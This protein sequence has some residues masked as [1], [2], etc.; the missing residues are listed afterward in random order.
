MRR[1]H[2]C[3]GLGKRLHVTAKDGGFLLGSATGVDHLK[4]DLQRV[5]HR[6]SSEVRE[7]ADP[8][9]DA[10][11]SGPLARGFLQ[12]L[13]RLDGA[14]AFGRYG[15]VNLSHQRHR[16]EV[17]VGIGGA[18]HGL[19][20]LGVGMIGAN[21]VAVGLG[22]H[23]REHA[24]RATGPFD[25]HDHE[26]LPDNGLEVLRREAIDDVGRAA[27]GI[28]YDN[29]DRLFRIDRLCHR[30][31]RWRDDSN[32]GSD[33]QMLQPILHCFLLW[34]GVLFAPVSIG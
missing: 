10:D 25:V 1:Q 11:L 18:A 20:A 30:S 8:H 21:R 23:R 27:G 32:H 15:Q 33:D 34:F 6:R 9:G 7:R 2:A 14:V 5:P 22:T 28:G 31:E 29:L 17:I 16:H 4:I 19:G 24:D 12:V 13:K 3:D 26:R